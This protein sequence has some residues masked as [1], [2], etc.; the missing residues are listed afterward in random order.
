MVAKDWGKKQWEVTSN[1]YGVALWGD[2]SVFGSDS[3][4]G[5][6]NLCIY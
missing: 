4:Y 3:G 6:I 5:C 2:E 1:R